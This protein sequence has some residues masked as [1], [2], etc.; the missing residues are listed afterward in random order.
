[1]ST[2]DLSIYSF[3]PTKLLLTDDALVVMGTSYV[4]NSDGSHS[5]STTVMQLWDVSNR[6]APQLRKTVQV[7]GNLLS[8]RMVERRVYVVT[9]TYPSWIWS[10]GE[11][12]PKTLRNVAPL[13]REMSPA[14]A[15]KAKL[16]EI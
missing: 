12:D 3:T 15:G 13:F 7:E 11:K 6:A 9:E 14:V 1:V 5:F 10:G 8:A 16:V 2:T 4:S